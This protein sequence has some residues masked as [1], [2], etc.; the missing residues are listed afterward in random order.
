M[1]NEANMFH[2]TILDDVRPTMSAL[3]EQAFNEAN[4]TLNSSTDFVLQPYGEFGK[5]QSSYH[6]LR[7]CDLQYWV[8][9]STI[10]IRY[11]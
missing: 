11:M 3:F 10:C 2:P 6:I 7:L 5:L 8:V 9:Q 1:E 4:I